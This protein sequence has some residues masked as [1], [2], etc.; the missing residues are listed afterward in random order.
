MQFNRIRLSGFKSFVEPTELVIEPGLTGVVGPNGCGKSNLLEA[1]RWVM[2]ESSYKRMRASGMDDV[3]FS[4]CAGRPARNMADVTVT[5]DNS[6]RTAPAGF[7]DADTLEITRR[8]EREAGSA[9]RINGKDAR[10]K[11]V[12]L[13][14]AD[15]STGS[16][17]PALV[18]Q[19]QISEIVS[20]KPQ[21][22][23][24]ILEEA[25]GI[26]GL[27]TRRHEAELRLNAAETNLTRLEDVVGQ[28]EIQLN[29]LKR[30]ARQATRYKNI[31]SDIRKV[32]A[33]QLFLEWSDATQAHETEEQGLHES[34]RALGEATRGAA[35]AARLLADAGDKLPPLREQ[36]AIKA[37]I[38]QRLTVERETLDAEEQRARDRKSELETR[39][40]QIEQDM[41][42]ERD[43][44]ADTDDALERL[45]GEESELTE[46]QNAQ[47][48]ARTDAEAAV[49]AAYSSL[50]ASEQQSDEMARSLSERRAQRSAIERAHRDLAQRLDKLRDDL[51]RTAQ[52][53]ETLT[54]RRADMPGV[55]ALATQLEEAEQ[56]A[57]AAHVSVE[58]AETKH[59]E[60][61]K[62]EAQARQE[63]EGLRQAAARLETELATLEKI[64]AVNDDDL[65]PPL[66]DAVRVTEGF[67]IALGAALGDDLDV[68]ADEA[69]PIHWRTLPKLD[70]SAPL[71][72]GV[73]ALA[74]VTD[75]PA[76]LAR[77][78]SQ[79]G[80]VEPDQGAKLQASLRPGQRLVSKQGDL[81]RW[82]GYTASAEAPTAA[83]QRLAERNRLAG[84]REDADSANRA[85]ARS[86]ADFT[87]AQEATQSAGVLVSERRQAARDGTAALAALRDALARQEK[88]N[89]EVTSRLAVLEEAALRLTEDTA[90]SST[91]F[92]AATEELSALG[93]D[94]ALE[95]QHTTLRET[96]A[97]A[98]AAYAE[99]KSKCDGLVREAE[100][101]T[102]RLAA[103]GEERRGWT[104]RTAR[105]DGQI[106]SLTERLGEADEALA[107]M[108]DLPR[109]WEER[110]EKLF[111]ALTQAENE[112]KAAADAL[113]L[114]ESQ[115]SECQTTAKRVDALAAECREAYA[116]LE[117]RL[118]A[119]RERRSDVARR[120][121]EQLHCAPEE[122][123]ELAGIKADAELPDRDAVEQKITR[124]RNER[125]RLGGV[126]L[127]ADEEAQEVGE[128]LDTLIAERDDLVSAI[129]R[130]RQGI[131]SLNKEG[132]ERLVAAFE[133]VN[134]NF[135]QLFT[136]LFGGGKA[137]LEFVESDDPLEAG[138]EIIAR[139]PG[140]RTQVLSLLSGGEQALTALALIFA[141]FLTNPSPICVLDEC[142]A[143]LDDANVERFCNLLTEMLER[144]DTRFLIITHHA[145]TMSRMNRLFGVTM[146]E[147]GVS[148][149]VSVDLET[150]EQ[151]REAG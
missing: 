51:A 99:E 29:N 83:A 76:A 100:A 74:D 46:A 19:G 58:D 104:E 41:V 117:E 14:F 149:L 119:A 112:R 118:A 121:E 123:R 146:A 2:G 102:K 39:R 91:A 25:A 126:N 68:P 106:V 5:L 78:L 85:V 151:Y 75:A 60:A 142:D 97:G 94:E 130:L 57:A 36:E 38:L 98:R 37:A 32:E 64:L 71:P 113:A 120:I 47:A 28:L 136:T 69:A 48:T 131:S 137:E 101:R 18:R 105:A 24:R 145:L 49:E 42:R 89:H 22:R 107:A 13:L 135:E 143:P 122:A 139:P 55:A 1:L 134:A 31:S 109:A 114:A 95:A 148:Q 138:L 86:Q 23:R 67:E 16:R 45:A 80:L 50:Q 6:Q 52:E 115:L 125:E 128:Q 111:R 12:Q 144:T 81:W 141:V 88:S 43:I 62:C 54:A 84:L 9:Y 108:A 93:S 65:W 44:I 77:R 21:A 79:V 82:D 63:L 110:R 92:D 103:I 124:L 35:E 30:Q 34:Q 147:R 140:K 20:S 27:H 53:T 3:I 11:D 87:V 129:Q 127:R 72:D 96:V 73:R 4:G 26:T 17:S 66:I 70:P 7:N 133:T 56:A 8:I 116:R 61:R 10:A 132:R 40:A 90:Q 150:A 59:D 15:A 33:A